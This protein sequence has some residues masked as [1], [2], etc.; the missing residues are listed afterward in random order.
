MHM[1]MANNDHM[2]AGLLHIRSSVMDMC[3]CRWHSE[4]LACENGRHEPPFH[5]IFLFFF[6]K[7]THT[8]QE[9]SRYS[10]IPYFLL[11]KVHH[12]NTYILKTKQIAPTPS[13]FDS[14]SKTN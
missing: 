11:E 8:L 14:T 4:L 2:V 9:A 3:A 7:K 12:V 6:L 1:F 13:A 10:S 5:S